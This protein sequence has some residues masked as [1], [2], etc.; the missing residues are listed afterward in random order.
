MW[1]GVALSNGST[2][3]ESRLVAD[4]KSAMEEMEMDN[5]CT[6]GSITNSSDA[7]MGGVDGRVRRAVMKRLRRD[8]HNAAICKSRWSHGSGLPAGM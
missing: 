5:S 7:V 1:Q 3:V 2:V 4:V 8:G 6:D